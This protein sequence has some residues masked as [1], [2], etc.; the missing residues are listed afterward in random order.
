VLEGP[1]VPPTKGIPAGVMIG[2]ALA[3]CGPFRLGALSKMREAEHARRFKGEDAE[4]EPFRGSLHGNSTLSQSRTYPSR[5]SWRH[6]GRRWGVQQGNTL[7][8]TG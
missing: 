3:R 7:S 5:S 1:V 8:R 6:Q 2:A 4:Q